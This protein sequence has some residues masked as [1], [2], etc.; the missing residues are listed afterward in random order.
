MEGL[1][2]IVGD[3]VDEW[4]DELYD[5][6]RYSIFTQNMMLAEKVSKRQHLSPRSSRLREEDER[7]FHS[8]DSRPM[9]IIVRADSPTIPEEDIPT[10]TSVTELGYIPRPTSSTTP[11]NIGRPRANARRT[12]QTSQSSSADWTWRPS[13]PHRVSSMGTRRKKITVPGRPDLATFHRRSCQLFTSLDTTLSNATTAGSRDTVSPDGSHTSTSPSLASSISTQA[14]SVL[15][16]NWY[17]TPA[18]PSF[19]LELH[20]PG[21]T[22]QPSRPYSPDFGDFLGGVNHTPR[23][24]ARRSSSQLSPQITS[25]E[26]MYWTSD[27]TRSNEYA[28]IDAAH[29]GLKGFVKRLLPRSWSWVHGKRRNFHPTSPALTQEPMAQNDDDSVR[30]YRM[31]I[32]SATQEA[33]RGAEEH[34]VSGMNTPI[35]YSTPSPTAG[36]TGPEVTL[37]TAALP[38]A[39]TPKQTKVSPVN[40]VLSKVRSSDA[41]TKMFRAQSGKV[42]KAERRAKTLSRELGF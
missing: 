13:I 35:R 16:D 15:D 22:L 21:Q 5:P 38:V 18:F 8:A 30:R 39:P 41:L 9:S 40:K 1:I 33:I 26:P 37:C 32:A 2:T 27:A 29:S 3:G 20:A 31:S 36:F 24:G 10:T 19:H 7:S 11:A 4:D 6:N 12:R 28:K 25:T 17:A 14:T 42:G 34:G 23:I